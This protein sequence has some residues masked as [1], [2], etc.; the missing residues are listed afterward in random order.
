VSNLHRDETRPTCLRCQ[1]LGFDCDG[2]KELV[3][4]DATI[5]ASR[6]KAGPPRGAPLGTPN[7]STVKAPATTQLTRLAATIPENPQEHY[8]MFTR[9][10]LTKDGPVD[11]ALRELQA[12]D[13][14]Q[15]VASRTTDW[16][17]AHLQAVLSFATI[18]F[19]TKHR[20]PDI[21][22]E[23]YI[24]HG[25]TLQQLNRAL[26]QPDCYQSDEI[27]VSVT[28]LA[29]QETLVP[30][31]PS[32]FMSHMEGM[33]KLLALRDPRLHCSPTSVSLYRCL[34]YMLIF[35]SL[36][37]GTPSVLARLDWKEMFHEHC[38][39]QQEVQEQQ[40]YDILA[41][42]SVLAFE[43][44][45]LLKSCGIDGDDL[46]A[47]FQNLRHNAQAVYDQLQAWRRHWNTNPANAYIEVPAS[48]LSSQS[49]GGSDN[50]IAN[51]SPTDI[52]FS[53]TTSALMLMLYNIALINLLKV[54]I[55]LPIEALPSASHPNLIAVV[56]FAVS[57]VYQ[58][59]PHASNAEWQKELHAAPIVYW[60]EQS[61]RMILQGD[62]SVEA[63]WLIKMLDQKST[64]PL[65]SKSDAV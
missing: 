18:L 36:T 27:I 64:V 53:N 14:S 2:P 3:F 8:I 47:Q 58:S 42:C 22:Q 21:T 29:I 41:D 44:G 25:A 33:E 34:R 12:R 45:E 7:A 24:S 26:S 49:G 20:H 59:L 10:H 50:D 54:L 5:V 31:G 35:A 52:V 51:T 62:E 9:S 46:N 57:E 23:G 1:R 48:W 17:T 16:Q 6:R 56:Y 37:A 60:A 15:L 38:A 13:I 55:S 39:N 19:G 40:L 28:T 63:K 65:A 11:I 4:I 43:R 30:S 32:L 61:A